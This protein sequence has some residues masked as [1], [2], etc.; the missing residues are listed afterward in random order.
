MAG[1]L[2]MAVVYYLLQWDGTTWTVVDEVPPLGL[3]GPV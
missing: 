2:A 1:P 3:D